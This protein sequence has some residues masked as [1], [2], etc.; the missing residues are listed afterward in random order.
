MSNKIVIAKDGYNALTE[1]NPNN[2]RFSSGYNTLKYYLTGNVQL[3]ITLADTSEHTDT[4]TVAHN[5]GYK[6][7]F[8]AYV[9]YLNWNF[10]PFSRWPV[11]GGQYINAYVDE[12]NFY[13]KMWAQETVA[14]SLPKTYTRTVYYRL[15]KNNLNFN[16]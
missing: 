14:G 12:N 5:L 9:D 7:F 6:P 3:S 4:E 15:F 11:T 13:A 1:T 2:L 16:V 8:I 10:C